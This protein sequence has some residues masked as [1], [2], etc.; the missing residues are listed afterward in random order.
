M[1][2]AQGCLPLFSIRLAK[3]IFIQFVSVLNLELGIPYAIL[4]YWKNLLVVYLVDR[5]EVI[6]T[7][8]KM[9]IIMLGRI[10]YLS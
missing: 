8:R 10:I 6:R 5:A 4:I 3:M 7:K 9:D 2:K 1:Q